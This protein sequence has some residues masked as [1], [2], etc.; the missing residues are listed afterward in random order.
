[1]ANRNLD[2]VLNPSFLDGV[3]GWSMDDLRS[4][5]T[6]VQS[7]EDAIS[8]L[9][10]LLQG[11]LDILGHE[12]QSRANATPSDR[13]LVETLV[14]TLSDNARPNNV[15][16][17]FLLPIAP[18]EAQA[19]WAIARADGAMPGVDIAQVPDLADEELHNLADALHTLERVVSDERR[20]LHD[21]LDV[22]QGEIVRRYKSGEASV[23][24]LLQ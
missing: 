16:G 17:R 19:S 24:G 14:A 15:G 6:E 18:A 12:L 5:R 9:R 2:R 1:M 21:I 7:L 23:E 4:A 10:R 22:L 8:M 20:Q 3:L 11:R 13:T